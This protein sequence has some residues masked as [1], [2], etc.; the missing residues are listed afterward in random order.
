MILDGNVN[1]L[2][3]RYPSGFLLVSVWNI[4]D[5]KCAS[6]DLGFDLSD[7][8]CRNVMYSINESFDAS[9]GINWDVVYEHIMKYNDQKEKANSD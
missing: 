7:S 4:E 1:E 8:D 5:V 6:I 3:S 9:I 2:T